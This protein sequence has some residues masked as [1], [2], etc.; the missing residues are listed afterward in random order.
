M[1][2]PRLATAI[3]D[4]SLFL[5]EDGR[6]VV[7]GP[8]DV[9]AFDDIARDRVHIVQRSWPDHVRFQHAGFETSSAADGPYAAAIVYLSR[10]KAD[11]QD[12]IAQ[13]SRQTGGGMIVIDGQKTDGVDSMLKACRKRAA[14]G[15]VI[16]R[17]H[18]KTFV[19]T[20]GDFSDWLAKPQHVS[21]DKEY[22]TAPGVFSA[23]GVDP[24]SAALAQA[25]PTTLKGRVADLGAGWGYLSAQVLKSD[26]VK[27]CHLFESDHQALACA[28]QNVADSRAH[29][30]W[31]D[32]T[33]L[34]DFGEFDVVVTNP[35]FH[36]GRAAD[37]GLGRAFI[38]T[39]A[40]LLR[41]KGV[42][43]LV[44]NRHLPYEAALADAF[45][46]VL[47]VTGTRAFKIICASHPRKQRR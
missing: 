12:T 1:A 13:A 33:D 15:Q 9:T 23:D 22:V 27:E 14:V 29:F 19:M 45:H 6:I 38:R 24:A 35:P 47:D 25:L 34:A 40:A 43:W 5:P 36:I 44:A 41:P 31:A 32:V 4:Q 10:A 42:L 20:G 30:H 26:A 18:G 8:T 7:F 3:R 16:S 46:T 39:S 11:I 17:G 28:R 37:P 2:A 21:D